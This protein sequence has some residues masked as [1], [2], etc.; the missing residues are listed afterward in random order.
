MEIKVN[1]DGE[2]I[3]NVNNG[4]TDKALEM[5]HALQADARRKTLAKDRSE[6]GKQAQTKVG[7]GNLN[8]IQYR[9]WEYLCE[10]DSPNGIHVSQLARAFGITNMAANSRL[11]VVE[12]LGYAKRVAK[13]YYRA[14]TPAE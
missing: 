10:N 9:T 14:L 8:A 5:I 6:T 4:E 2:V 7:S 3:L 11:L 12:K 13:G 1:A